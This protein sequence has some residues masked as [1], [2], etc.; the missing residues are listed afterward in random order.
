MNNILKI[1]AAFILSVLAW[2]GIIDLLYNDSYSA[3]ASL[4]ATLGIDPFSGALT[5]YASIAFACILLFMTLAQLFLNRFWMPFFIAEAILYIVTLLIVV[6]AKSQGIQEWNLDP[7]DILAQ[8]S[9]YPTSVLLNI[10]IFIPMGLIIHCRI[11]NTGKALLSA[12]VGVLAIEL[13]Q[14]VFALG[15]AD[16]VDVILNM[17]GFTIGYLSTQLA[18]DQGIR[19][20]RIEST[21]FHHL[22][23][24]TPNH[25]NEA[26]ALSRRSAIALIALIGIACFGFVLAYTFYDYDSY[27]E[28]DDSPQPTE[29]AILSTLPLAKNSMNVDRVHAELATFT[30][31][32]VSSSND[33]LAT[34]SDGFLSTEGVVTETYDW[35]TI[36]GETRYA[37]TL[38]IEETVGNTA[39]AHALP[40]VI[41]QDSRISL[42]GEKLDAANK[43][44]LSKAIDSIALCTG[45]VAFSLQD[46]WLRVERATFHNAIDVPTPDASI[47]YASYSQE[48]EEV[49]DESGHDVIFQENKVTNLEAYA[50]AYTEMEN[51]SPY[52]TI[53]INDCLGSA[54]ISHSL[55]ITCSA[56]P[57]TYADGM[58]PSVLPVT[59]SAQALRLIE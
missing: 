29:D 49:R 24:T 20:S 45:D 8:V 54:L 33:W 36:D 12:L 37:I 47:P 14:Y 5:A 3:L 2:F 22:V 55:N 28:W 43:A 41:T 51:E 10:T 13:L 58:E 27:V 42:D 19:L 25:H 44:A 52:L 38:A 39:V 4:F 56:Q 17:M 7:T 6:L 59:L 30:F 21:P 32:D 16:I 11:K 46:G 15:I 57:E 34:T 48:L 18:Y 50:D 9:L 40:L 53:R 1:A 23:R 31:G 35:L 26:H